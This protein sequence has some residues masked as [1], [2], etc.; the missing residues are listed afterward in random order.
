MVKDGIGS[1]AITAFV[2]WEAAPR[3]LTLR[4]EEIHIWRVPL[5]QPE[6]SVREFFNLLNPV[7]RERARRFH[8]QKDRDH[9]TVARGTLRLI[10]GRYLDIQPQQLCFNYNAYGKPALQIES[11]VIDLRFNLSHSHGLALMAIAA[12]AEIGVDVE[13]IRADFAGD[14]TIAS[15]FSEREAETIRALPPELRTQAFFACWTRK[16]AFIKAVGEGLSYPLDQ[17]SVSVIPGQPARLLNA[18]GGAQETG[19]W[20]LVELKCGA[21]YAA[22]LAVDGRIRRL[23]GFDFT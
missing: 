23:R 18:R 12:G 5:T 22:A 21:G 17:F 4:R 15:Y 16:E 13:W 7:E 10:L 8:F 3:N 14:A 20:S 1:L 9:F 11:G 6:P 19:R 2:D